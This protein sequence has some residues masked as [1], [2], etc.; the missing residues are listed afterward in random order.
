M[1]LFPLIEDS[2]ATG[3]VRAIFDDI[4]AT[5]QIQRVPN[6]WRALAAHPE[7]LELVWSRAKAIMK[8]G[9]LTL[10]NQQP[11]GGGAPCHI[12]VDASGK[13]ALVA[14]YGGGSVACLPIADDGRLSAPS[15]FIQHTGS[16]VNPQRQKEPHAHSINLDKANR[17][18][19]AADLAAAGKHA[20]EPGHGDRLSP[21]LAGHKDNHSGLMTPEQI[22]RE[23]YAFAHKVY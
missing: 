8:D 22:A 6:F 3:K 13:N 1:P 10:L 16:S 18:A 14:N 21:R 19:F 11:S 20:I 2:A 5:K 7:H 23:H 12:S 15:S 4:K 17:F 9:K